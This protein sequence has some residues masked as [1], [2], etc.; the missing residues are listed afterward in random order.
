M[1]EVHPFARLAGV[2]LLV[3]A[4]FLFRRPEQLLALYLITLP[5]LAASGVAARHF[6]FLV[7]VTLP[8]LAALLLLWGLIASP[9]AGEQLSGAGYAIAI[10]L[11]IVVLGAAFQWLLLPLAEHPLH[12][13]Q[14]LKM[15]RLPA[16][17]GALLIAPILLLPEIRRRIGRI[18]DARKAQGLPSRGF[19][20]A[21]ALPAMMMP[22]VA[23][24]LESSLARSELWTHRSLLDRDGNGHFEASYSLGQSAAVTLL[25]AAALAIALLA[26]TS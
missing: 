2:L 21:R 15:L 13:K 1:L 11:R 20:G 12:L 16:A 24:L 26:W 4:A 25:P 17:A 9:P 23:S 22:L 14:F 10:W 19:A 3:A 8:L 6:R 18:V 5:A 7:A